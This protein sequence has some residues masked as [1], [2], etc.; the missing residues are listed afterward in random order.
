MLVFRAL[1][2]ST[3]FEK[4]WELPASQLL[5]Y[6]VELHRNMLIRTFAAM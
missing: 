6:L 1:G 4:S 2:D 3:L 5:V